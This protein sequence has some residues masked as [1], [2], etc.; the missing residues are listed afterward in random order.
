MHFESCQKRRNVSLSLLA[1]EEWTVYARR[2]GPRID[3]KSKAQGGLV[4]NDLSVCVCFV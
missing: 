2:W 3:D 4:S 1:P